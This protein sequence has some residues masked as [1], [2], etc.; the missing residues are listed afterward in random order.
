MTGTSADLRRAGDVWRSWG[1][2]WSPRDEIHFQ[3]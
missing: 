1:G 2:D 3:A